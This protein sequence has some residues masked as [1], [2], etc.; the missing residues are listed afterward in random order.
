[1]L[2]H[3][4]NPSKFKKT[5]I[6]SSIYFSIHSSLKLEINYKTKTSKNTNTGSLNTMLLCITNGSHKKIKIENTLRQVKMEAQ[7][8][9]NLWDTT[10]FVLRGKFITVQ[11]YLRK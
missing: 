1:M 2:Y 9:E 4:A 8:S 11:A 6:I 5:E 7:L 10:K 3:I